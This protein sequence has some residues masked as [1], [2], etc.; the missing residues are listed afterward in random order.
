MP[1]KTLDREVTRRG[2][3]NW[4]LGTSAG[5]FLLSVLY[6]VSR[7]LIPPK[8]EESM[9]RAVTLSIKSGDVKV[10]TGEIFKFGN[11]P[12]ILIRTPAGE[13]R[14]FSAVCTHLACIVQYRPDLH[15]V[16][17]A[18]HNGHFDLNGQNIVGPPPRPLEQYVVNVRGDQ[19]VVSKGA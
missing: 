2:F 9:A 17:C 6:P 5:A 11:R 10:N 14:A 7:Y 16:W 1:E 19:V 13:L 15:H 3:I 4:V 8:V 18:C 12:A